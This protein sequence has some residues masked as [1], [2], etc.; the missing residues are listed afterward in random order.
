MLHNK[1]AISDSC[2]MLPQAY[3]DRNTIKNIVLFLKIFHL[4]RT[5]LQHEKITL[6]PKG[7]ADNETV[8]L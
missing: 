5:G 6:K 4:L 1:R 2:L 3:F 8:F 7:D